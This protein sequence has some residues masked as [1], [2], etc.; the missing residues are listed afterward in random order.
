MTAYRMVV[1]KIIKSLREALEAEVDGS[2]EYEVRLRGR[3][4]VEQAPERWLNLPWWGLLL[5]VFFEV[6]LTCFHRCPLWL[7]ADPAQG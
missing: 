1:E 6:L 5:Q 7:L 2:N 4:S 3:L